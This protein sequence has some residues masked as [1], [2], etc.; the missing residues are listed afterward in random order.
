MKKLTILYLLL[1]IIPFSVKAQNSL[2]GTVSDS[3]GE[4]LPGAVIKIAGT[5]R[6]YITDENGA[7]EIPSIRFPARI[8]VSYVG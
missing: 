4:P 3:A 5:D 1:L 6:G 8:I 2:R 7:Y